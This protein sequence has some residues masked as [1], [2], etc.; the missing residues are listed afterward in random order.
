M[1]VVKV[2]ASTEGPPL[3]RRVPR[4]SRGFA[5]FQ[6]AKD[7]F[8]NDDGVVDQARK[9]Q[10]QASQN[11]RVDRTAAKEETM[12]VASAERGMERKTA[13]VARKLP[14]KTRIINAGEN[15]PDG[16]LMDEVFNGAF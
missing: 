8:Q 15:E 11:H 6:V 1:A 3:C 10:G 12:K 9:S 2:A 5:Q 13:S 16:T 7:I 4:P 14:R